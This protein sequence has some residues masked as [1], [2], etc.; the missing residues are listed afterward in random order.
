MANS[1]KQN[2]LLL[3]FQYMGEP[4]VNAPF[5]TSITDTRQ[6]EFQNSGKPFVEFEKLTFHYLTIVLSN[7]TYNGNAFIS[8][9]I[10]TLEASLRTQFALISNL[11]FRGV[12][13]S[14]VRGATDSL[15]L[16]LSA[17]YYWTKQSLNSTEALELRTAINSAIT[18]VS[19]LSV[20]EVRLE[21]TLMQKTYYWNVN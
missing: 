13:C 21:S 5:E 1:L 16:G 4:F 7:C 17:G 8:S 12:G 3:N 20:S 6:G 14:M 11:E 19:G 15:T 9:D 2:L 18:N 10:E